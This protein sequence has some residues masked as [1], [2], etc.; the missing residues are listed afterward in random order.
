V[1]LDARASDRVFG[2]P[3][4]PSVDTTAPYHEPYGLETTDAEGQ[5]C[6]LG[7]RK[8]LEVGHPME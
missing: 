8:P 7:S 3:R 6:G 4:D 1:I 2:E 5:T